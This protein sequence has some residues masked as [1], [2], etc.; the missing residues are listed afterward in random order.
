MAP[1]VGAASERQD[2][3]LRQRLQTDCGTSSKR[4]C[5]RDDRH[6]RII[7]Y[8]A[9]FEIILSLR[10]RTDCEVCFTAEDSLQQRCVDLV[11]HSNINVRI[12]DREGRN[13]LR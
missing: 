1:D 13:G 2:W 10:S 5:A 9:E 3:Q 12:V 11:E 4:V 8:W 6:E 7:Q